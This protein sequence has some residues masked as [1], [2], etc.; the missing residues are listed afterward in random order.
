MLLRLQLL[1]GLVGMLP[2]GIGV[3]CG[4]WC[5]RTAERHE[6]A[7]QDQSHADNSFDHTLTLSPISLR[8]FWQPVNPNG[9][10]RRAGTV[11]RGESHHRAAVKDHWRMEGSAERVQASGR[12]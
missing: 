6:E 3:R 9:P 2:H 7:A 12:G 11:H 1:E 4:R 10:A 5:R 8:L